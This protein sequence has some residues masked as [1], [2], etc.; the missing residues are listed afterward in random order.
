MILIN[1][2]KLLITQS[3]LTDNKDIQWKLVEN[4]DKG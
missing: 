2:I 4:M 3:K 1:K